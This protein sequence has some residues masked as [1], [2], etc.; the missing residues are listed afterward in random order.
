MA[1]DREEMR[2]DE[3][4]RGRHDTEHEHGRSHAGS[5]QH[6]SERRSENENRSADSGSESRDLKEREY[7]DQEGNIHHHTRTSKEMKDER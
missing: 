4:A 2:T 1:E 3:S 7:R 6:S 5:K